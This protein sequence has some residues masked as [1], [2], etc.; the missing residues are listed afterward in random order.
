[1]NDDDAVNGNDA[2]NSDVDDEQTHGI[3]SRSRKLAT[4]FIIMVW[5]LGKPITP[6]HDHLD[7]NE[8]KDTLDDDGDDN[9]DIHPLPRGIWSALSHLIMIT[10]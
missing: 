5:A 6:D 10:F 8:G 3:A 4:L 9:D 2:V 7:E 1:M